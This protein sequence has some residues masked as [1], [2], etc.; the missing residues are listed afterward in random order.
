[1]PLVAAELPLVAAELPLLVLVLLLLLLPTEALAPELVLPVK[2]P[3]H[4]ERGVPGDDAP[5]GLPDSDP[6]PDVSPAGEEG[7]LAVGW[8]GVLAAGAEAGAGAGEACTGATATGGAMGAGW[9]PVETAPSPGSSFSCGQTG[10]KRV[11]SWPF[12][13]CVNALARALSWP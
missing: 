2:P 6:D 1:M 7:K 11:F 12:S 13:S 5:P 9:V 10:L 3:V 4:P 8:D